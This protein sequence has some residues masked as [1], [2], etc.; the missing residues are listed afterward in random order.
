M[1][2]FQEGAG[3]GILAA[4]PPSVRVASL[5]GAPGRRRAARMS[6]KAARRS[7]LRGRTS[8]AKCARAGKRS[9]SAPRTAARNCSARRGDRRAVLAGRDAAHRAGGP[10]E[11]R[12]ID[13]GLGLHP[14]EPL[15]PGQEPC[16]GHGGTVW[17]AGRRRWRAP[18]AAGGGASPSTSGAGTSSTPPAVR[19]RTPSTRRWRPSTARPRTADRAGGVSRVRQL[20]PGR[21]AGGPH[22]L[23]TP[24]S[25]TLGAEGT[26][27]RCG[28]SSRRRGCSVEGCG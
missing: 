28:C 6:S 12:T 27:T 5:S 11:G 21:R 2:I 18:T 20:P 23:L 4:R 13:Y 26:D 15:G 8:R 14:P 3:T 17:A 25:P 19:S 16:W 24:P 7:S 22:A 10:Q 1:P 9:G